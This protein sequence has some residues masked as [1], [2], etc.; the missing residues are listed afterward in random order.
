[1]A[2]RTKQKP[3]KRITVTVDPDDYDTLNRLA[4]ETDVSVLWLIRR[5][6]REFRDRHEREGSVPIQIGRARRT[7][8][9]GA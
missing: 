2:Y 6:M 4:Q 5:M 1:M 9:E 8:T 3:L 7:Q